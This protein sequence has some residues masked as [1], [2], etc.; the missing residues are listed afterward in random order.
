MFVLVNSADPNGMMPYNTI[1]KVWPES[2]IWVQE[3]ACGNATCIMVKRGMCIKRLF[4][5]P[6]EVKK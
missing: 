5:P 3:K 6:Y 1:Y 4:W 2:I